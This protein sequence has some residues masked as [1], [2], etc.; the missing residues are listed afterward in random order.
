MAAIPA[1]LAYASSSQTLAGGGSPVAF[2]ANT[3]VYDNGSNYNPSNY[4]FTA[5]ANGKYEFLLFVTGSNSTS[6]RLICGVKVNSTTYNGT[7][8]TDTFSSGFCHLQI[9]LS[10]GDTVQPMVSANPANIP[11]NIGVI[12]S[13]FSGKRI[14]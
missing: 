12:A 7:Q 4:T 14:S 3:E 6:S 2:Q 10:A 9:N 5:P 8:Q 11:T 13:R 1:F